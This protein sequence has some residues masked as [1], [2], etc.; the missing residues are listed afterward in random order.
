MEA[1]YGLDGTN[2]LSPENPITVILEDAVQ[3]SEYTKAMWQNTCMDIINAT[4][5]YAVQTCDAAI[6]AAPGWD[7]KNESLSAFHARYNGL[8]SCARWVRETLGKDA[9]YDWLAPYLDQWAAKLGNDA[10]A[11][12]T[13][14]LPH[15]STL[16][17]Y[18]MAVQKAMRIMSGDNNGSKRT[19]H[20]LHTMHDTPAKEDLITVIS[21]MVAN[22]AADM[23]QTVKAG[24]RQITARLLAIE[25]RPI[26]AIPKPQF[27]T[28]YDGRDGPAKWGGRGHGYDSHRGGR[29]RGNNRYRDSRNNDRQNGRY[30]DKE[31]GRGGEQHGRS[32]SDRS[33][34]RDNRQWQNGCFNCDREGHRSS[35]CTR[36]CRICRSTKHSSYHCPDRETRHK[37]FKRKQPEAAD[38]NNQPDKPA[39]NE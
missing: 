17:A 13:L 1:I 24:N 7:S 9:S 28:N 14:S 11:A 35:D 30:G 29:G 15:G 12:S 23:A 27:H 16:Y 20:Q 36:A 2:S 37:G 26:P 4:C 19:T 6:N 10:L 8:L 21:N 3:R 31:R 5:P 38:D 18:Y 33:R 34:P 22:T 32:H 25:D 39:K